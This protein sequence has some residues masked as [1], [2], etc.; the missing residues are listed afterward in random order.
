MLDFT[1]ENGDQVPAVEQ[2]DDGWISCPYNCTDETH[3]HGVSGDPMTHR[4]SHCR[5]KAPDDTGYFL[6]RPLPG[7]LRPFRWWTLKGNPAVA[8]FWTRFRRR[9]SR[10]FGFA[11]GGDHPDTDAP[12]L[13]PNLMEGSDA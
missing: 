5:D 3:E 8:G 2:H 6:M 10:P 1:F 13:L 9:I 11:V 7:V 4:A 12:G